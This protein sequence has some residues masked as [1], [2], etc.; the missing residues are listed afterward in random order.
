MCFQPLKLMYKRL[1]GCTKCCIRCGGCSIG[2]AILLIL[3]GAI[4]LAVALNA[5]DQNEESTKTVKIVGGLMVT[6]GAVSII[7]AII[8]LIVMV[9]KI[10]YALDKAD[11]KIQAPM[12]AIHPPAGSYPKQQMLDSPEPMAVA[13]APPEEEV[14][15]VTIRV[16]SSNPFEGKES[17]PGGVAPSAPS[18]QDKF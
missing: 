17:L 13:T 18:Q 11:G 16:D 3:I 15:N 5:L 14:E 8:G 12:A 2:F 10:K 6:I 4:M 9:H 7:V 1:T